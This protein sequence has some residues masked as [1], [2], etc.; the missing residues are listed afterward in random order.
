MF[1]FLVFDSIYSINAFILCALPFAVCHL[2]ALF[3][4]VFNYIHS[5]GDLLRWHLST[6]SFVF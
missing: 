1:F 4:S 5:D 6:V 2:R 3:N